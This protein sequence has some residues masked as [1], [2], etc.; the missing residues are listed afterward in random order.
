MGEITQG[1]GYQ[2]AQGVR[3]PLE[4][5]PQL[6]SSCHQR[7]PPVVLVTELRDRE[8]GKGQGRVQ[9]RQGARVRGRRASAGSQEAQQHSS[10][11]SDQR[12]AAPP[13]SANNYL[14]RGGS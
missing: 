11:F 10:R 12:E 8:A 7:W 9:R 6:A 5:G 2:E 4:R 13:V 14:T 1:Q 3:R